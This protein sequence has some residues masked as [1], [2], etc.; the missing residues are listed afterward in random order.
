MVVT[1]AALVIQEMS[2]PKYRRWRDLGAALLAC[3]VE[4]LG[5]RQATAWWRAEG[6]WKSLRGRTAV[7]GTMTRQGFGSGEGGHDEEP[8]AAS[9]PVAAGRRVVCDPADHH[10]REP[11]LHPR[12]GR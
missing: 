10:G 5:Y 6:W 3:V 2:F 8:A 7:W 11:D 12:G 4:N 9:A 1:R